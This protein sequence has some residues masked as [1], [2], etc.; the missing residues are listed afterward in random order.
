MVEAIRQGDIPGVQ[1][2]CRQRVDV[3]AETAWCWLTEVKF[4][5]CWIATTVVGDV[6]EGGRLLLSGFDEQDRNLQENVEFVELLAPRRCILQLTQANEKWNAVTKVSFEII[7]G[8][9]GCEVSVFHEGFEYLSLS[10]CL[11]YWEFYRR[12]WRG[13]LDRLATA[14]RNSPDES[15]REPER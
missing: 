9:G 6:G 7:P 13:A 8:E 11:T 1:V 14:A 3:P 10:E 12:R 5:E 15:A 4:L 2:R